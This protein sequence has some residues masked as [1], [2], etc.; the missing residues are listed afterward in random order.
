MS[1]STPSALIFALPLS[2]NVPVA[3]SV[4]SIRNP[5]L[6]TVIDVIF[7]F[8]EVGHFANGFLEQF[9][10]ILH[11]VFRQCEVLRDAAPIASG[12]FGGLCG[13]LEISANSFFD[14]LAALQQPQK[15]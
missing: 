9:F 1:I 10:Q 14:L 4:S 15:R 13:I 2:K 12:Q 8:V 7:Q 11:V 6:V 5:S 3:D